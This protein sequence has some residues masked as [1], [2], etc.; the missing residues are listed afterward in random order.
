MAPWHVA[1]NRKGMHQVIRN[2]G[3]RKCL[4]RQDKIYPMGVS[5]AEFAHSGG[6]GPW[7]RVEQADLPVLP[8]VEVAAPK[9]HGTTWPAAR[10][11]RTA[12]ATNTRER[13]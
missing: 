4:T 9:G 1:A 5:F 3:G 7:I 2:V 11:L 13:P 12:A 6:S 8:T 10:R